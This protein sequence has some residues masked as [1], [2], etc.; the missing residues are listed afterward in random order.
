MRG[1][2]AAVLL[3]VLAGSIAPP[4]NAQEA[5]PLLT[6]APGRCGRE[7]CEGPFYRSGDLEFGRYLI[8]ATTR[9]CEGQ[10]EFVE[11]GVRYIVVRNRVDSMRI[12]VSGGMVLPFGLR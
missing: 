2:L 1:G 12:D 4:A 10:C 9:V 7:R 8:G 3:A 5:Q 6:S 11:A